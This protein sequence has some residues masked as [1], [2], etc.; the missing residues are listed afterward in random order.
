MS[1]TWA[2][3]PS[4]IVSARLNNCSSVMLPRGDDVSVTPGDTT[5]TRM[6]SAAVSSA[7]ERAKPSIRLGRSVMRAVRRAAAGKGRGEQHDRTALLLPHKRQYG[8]NRDMLPL[9]LT[10]NVASHSALSISRNGF[11]LNTAAHATSPRTEPATATACSSTAASRPARLRTSTIRVR[12][13]G[14]LPTAR[15]ARPHRCR[16]RRREPHRRATAAPAPRQCRRCAGNETAPFVSGF[17][18]RATPAQE[19]ALDPQENEIDQKTEQPSVK[20]PANISGTRNMRCMS[21]MK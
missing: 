10:S 1:R 14:A 2:M 13:C 20:M 15:K 17:D 4:G 18:T 5:L 7:T 6:P 12:E 21:R 11:A 9:R 19:I 8:L 3:R 16:K